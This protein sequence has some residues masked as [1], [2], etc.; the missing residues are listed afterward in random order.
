MAFV[1]VADRRA[2]YPM[3]EKSCQV[4][5]RREERFAKTA[6]GWI[7]R[8]ISKHDEQF[9]RRVV[10]ENIQH[11]SRE[12]LKNATKYFSED[13]RDAAIQMLKHAQA[14]AGR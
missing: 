5:I 7:L 13:E 1:K 4:L 3:V 10:E 8:D 6:V 11:F 2:Y 14:G 9:V 12:S